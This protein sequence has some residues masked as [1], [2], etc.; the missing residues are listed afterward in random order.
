MGRRGKRDRYGVD[1][2]TLPVVGC[3]LI[4]PFGERVRI[5][6]QKRFGFGVVVFVRSTKYR[7]KRE[8]LL[9]QVME[10]VSAKVRSS[11]IL[12]AGRTEGHLLGR[13]RDRGT[14][15]NLVTP[16]SQAK[17]QYERLI[18][19]MMVCTHDVQEFFFQFFLRQFMHCVVKGSALTERV[20]EG[21]EYG[22]GR[23]GSRRPGKVL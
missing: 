9:G 8:F 17:I 22:L 10:D 1:E 11:V 7:V 19:R 15:K 12:I 16:W 20:E 23:P 14:E 4:L 3:I 5:V 21:G 13:A 6:G 2:L 18:A